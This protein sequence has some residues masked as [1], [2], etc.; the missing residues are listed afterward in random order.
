MQEKTDY[1]KK[2]LQHEL[3]EIVGAEYVVTDQAE[4]DCQS[5]DVWWVTRYRFF[6]GTD[7]PQPSAIVFP[8][9]KQEVVRLVKF[10][11]K[12]KV[13]FVPRGGGAGDSGGS[14]ALKDGIIIDLKRMNRVLELNEKSLTVRVQPGIIQ[15][16]LE[17]YLNRRGYTMN[18]FPASFNTSA[19]GGFISTNGTGVLSSRYGKICD[20]VHQLVRMSLKV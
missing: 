18:H 6:K 1:L 14:L 9:N 3:E 8:G 4:I 17:E 13:P 2:F 20:M 5:I 16:H 11:S 7:F 12:H 19:L 15:K 10:C